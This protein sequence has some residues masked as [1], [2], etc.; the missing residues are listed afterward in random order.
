MGI[1]EHTWKSASEMTSPEHKPPK[2]RK[3]FALQDHYS[4]LE[5]QNAYGTSAQYSVDHQLL[6]QD[7]TIMGKKP[8]ALLIEL[9]DRNIIL[10]GLVAKLDKRI[11]DLEGY[12][13]APGDD[14]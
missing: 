5:R 10:E 2:T 7:A 9:L 11:G 8:S 14:F 12:P 4:R 1:F 13:A 3:A 6:T